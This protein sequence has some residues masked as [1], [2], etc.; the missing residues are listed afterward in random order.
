MEEAEAVEVVAVVKE[1]A[2][3]EGL[4]GLNRPRRTHHRRKRTAARTGWKL[5]LCASSSSCLYG[6]FHCWLLPVPQAHWITEAPSVVL[7]AFTSTHRPLKRD[8]M[9]K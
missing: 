3:A 2:P 5:L 8:L 4:P 6:F 1:E 7:T 9:R